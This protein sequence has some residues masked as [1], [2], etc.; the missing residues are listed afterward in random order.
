MKNSRQLPI[1]HEQQN[2]G[3]IIGYYGRE[4]NVGE[5]PYLSSRAK[6]LEN[7][8][9]EA[10]LVLG[11]PSKDSNARYQSRRMQ[12]KYFLFAVQL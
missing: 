8:F 11:V 5:A 7:P 2:F 3:Q 10:V 6:F 4:V 9:A 12:P 1:Q